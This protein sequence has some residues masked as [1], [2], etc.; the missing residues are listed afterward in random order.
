MS[1]HS[2][3]GFHEFMKGL[4]LASWWYVGCE[5]LPLASEEVHN[6]SRSLMKKG[7]AVHHIMAALRREVVFSACG[8]D[9]WGTYI[10]RIIHTHTS[11][12]QTSGAVR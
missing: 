1:M 10:K 6:V 5:A 11:R 8:L 12:R 4:P 2:L 9:D 3:G 7:P